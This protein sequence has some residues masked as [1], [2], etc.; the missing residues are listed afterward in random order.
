MAQMG[1]GVAKSAEMNNSSLMRMLGRSTPL[2]VGDR[3]CRRHSARACRVAKCAP[4][5][6]SSSGSDTA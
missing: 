6:I 1:M 2:D 5:R 4:S 3:T